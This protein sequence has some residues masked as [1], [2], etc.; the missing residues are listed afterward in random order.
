MLN[1]R[2]DPSRPGPGGIWRRWRRGVSIQPPG[3]IESPPQEELDLRVDAAQVVVRP[4]LQGEER[5]LVEAEQE[6]LA[7]GH[8]GVCRPKP[9]AQAPDGKGVRQ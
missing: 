6:G 3:L 5:P 8:G 2:P 9:L 4:T 1:R 7:F